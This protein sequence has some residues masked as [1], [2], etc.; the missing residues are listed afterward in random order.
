MEKVGKHDLDN[1]NFQTL[2]DDLSSYYQK[3]SQNEKAV[4]L[5]S[6]NMLTFTAGMVN[7]YYLEPDRFLTSKILF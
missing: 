4:Q 6:D 7:K 1:L 5:Y 2:Y 3:H